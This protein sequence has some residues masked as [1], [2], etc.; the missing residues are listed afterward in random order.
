V[1]TESEIW[2]CRTISSVRAGLLALLLTNSLGLSAI[3][4]QL[5]LYGPPGSSAFGTSVTVLANGN[6]VVT[7]PGFSSDT[8]TAV[9]AVYLYTP[10]GQ[11]I[12]TLTGSSSYDEVG[13]SI[14]AGPTVVVLKNGNFLVRSSQWHNGDIVQAGAVT[15]G[16]AVFGVSGTVSAANSL[17]G[18]AVSDHVGTSVTALSNGNYVVAS[19]KWNNF[20]GAAT[21][22]DGSVGTAGGVSSSNSLVGSLAQDQVSSGGVQALVNGSYVV[23]S[24]QW[25][26][27]FGATTWGNGN[28]GTVGEVSATNSLVGG[29]SSGDPYSIPTTFYGVTPLAN[30]NYVV[31][32]SNW[33]GGFGSATWGNGS[34]GVVGSIS[35]SNSLVGS[36]STDQVGI[37]VTAL[38]NGNYVVRA[39]NWNGGRGAATW[40]NGTAGTSGLVTVGNSIVGSATDAVSNYG[41]FALSNGNYVVASPSWNGGTGA[42]TWGNGVVGTHETVSPDNS[43][44]GTAEG[45][46]VGSYVSTLSNGNYLVVSSQWNGAR[47]AVTWCDGEST[48]TKTVDSTNSFVG[49]SP[50]TN[51][52]AVTALTNGN[53]AIGSRDWSTQ[54]STVTWANGTTGITGSPSSG[55]SFAGSPVAVALNDG[56]YVATNT[57]WNTGL[58]SVTWIN[59]SMAVAG[60]VSAQN[61]IVGTTAGDYLG[62]GGV[63]SAGQHDFI[64]YSPH[65]S[66]GDL[67]LSGAVSLVRG[68]SQVGQTVNLH[69]SVLAQEGDSLAF[70]Y[71]AERDQLVVGRPLENIVSL[72][73]PD[74]LLGNGFD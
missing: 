59:G 10:D 47:G 34:T 58:G 60:A 68:R 22:G 48:A 24:Q 3:A 43:V 23:M 42:A 56:N 40:G 73:K 29:A 53:Y 71:D 5:D 15:W 35:K 57:N 41:V 50:N 74:E 72:F 7:D 16:S 62:S 36:S 52:G 27:N 19:P 49:A 31:Y 8:A 11:L 6:V 61:S 65:F 67:F 21:W 38:T 51:L 9:G 13:G 55:N 54:I 30:G 64:V 37:G 66:N 14:E 18:T 26:A 17:V 4:Q 70:A 1:E 44:V 63:F 20:R 32:S 28:G 25:N 33:N 12:S 39:S 69:N 2:R 45:D 46:Q